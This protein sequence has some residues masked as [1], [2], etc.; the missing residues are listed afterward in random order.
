MVSPLYSGI[1]PQKL[2]DYEEVQ[3]MAFQPHGSDGRAAPF[4]TN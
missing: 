2:N 4:G 3:E 1:I